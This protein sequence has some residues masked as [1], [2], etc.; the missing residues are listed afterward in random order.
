MAAGKYKKWLES[1]DL[2]RLEAWARNDL[3]YEQITKNMGIA[4]ATLY[5]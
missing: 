5:E 1:D 4:R 2:L 3:T